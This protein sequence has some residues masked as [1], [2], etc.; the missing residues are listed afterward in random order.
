MVP[1]IIRKDKDESTPVPVVLRK[2]DELGRRYDTETGDL[3]PWPDTERPVS[4]KELKRMVAASGVERAGIG[5]R[6]TET[7]QQ[8]RD[9]KTRTCETHVR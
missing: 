8:E 9:A 7:F 3:V 1:D 2:L 6:N 4:L 5:G